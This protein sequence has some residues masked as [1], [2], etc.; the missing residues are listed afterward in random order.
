MSV[1]A[2]EPPRLRLAGLKTK[3]AKAKEKARAKLPKTKLA[4][5]RGRSPHQRLPEA[6]LQRG[7]TLTWRASGSRSCCCWCFGSGF[8]PY[9]SRDPEP[10]GFCEFCSQ[11]Y[12]RMATSSV[13]SM[14]TL[15]PWLPRKRRLSDAPTSVALQ[16]SGPKFQ[17]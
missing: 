4:T 12:F 14:P 7:G 5:Q 13:R 15:A 11:R 17:F 16:L 6:L 3:E 8:C 10:S 9:R 2:S 1:C